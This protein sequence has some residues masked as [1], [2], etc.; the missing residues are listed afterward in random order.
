MPTKNT[1]K[2]QPSKS[3]VTEFLNDYPNQKVI[4][5]CHKLIKIFEDV[6]GQNPVI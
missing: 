1:N 3:S 4:P 2:T 5:D 6:T